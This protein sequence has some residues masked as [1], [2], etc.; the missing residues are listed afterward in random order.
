LVPCLCGLEQRR[1]LTPPARPSLPPLGSPDALLSASPAR[2]S[3]LSPA[4]RSS[5]PRSVPVLASVAADL[6]RSTIAV[7][8]TRCGRPARSRPIGRHLHPLAS[9]CTCCKTVG[10]PACAVPSCRPSPYAPCLGNSLTLRLALIC[11]IAVSAKRCCTGMTK[12]KCLSLNFA[13]AKSAI[14]SAAALPSMLLLCRPA[15]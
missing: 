6:S 14:V 4:T 8:T 12:V 9:T 3:L 2:T 13:G 1:R 15:P 7:V 10:L 11:R 5:A